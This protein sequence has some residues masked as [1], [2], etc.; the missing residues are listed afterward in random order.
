[1]KRVAL[2]GLRVIGA[3]VTLI[4]V[5]VGATILLLKTNWGG[6]RLRRQ[7]VTRV[8][9]QIQGHLDVQRLAFGGNSLT[10]WEVALRDPDGGTVAHVARVE[11]DFSVT[12]LLHKEINLK[13]IAIESPRLELVTDARGSNLARAT[14]PRKKSPP[15]PPA[16]PKT[17]EEGWVVR[18]DRFDLTGGE[19]VVAAGGE[20]PAQT[21]VHLT[22]LNSF[23]RVRYA[24]GN[25][26]LDLGFRLQGQS[27]VAPVAPLRISADAQVRGDQYR[28]NADGNLLNGT[29]RAHGNVDSAHLDSADAL[30]A[31][32][33]PRQELGGYGWGPLR[34]DA[35]A[36][37]GV[38][39][40][41]DVALSIPGVQLTG[42]SGQNAKDDA[43]TGAKTDGK[44][45]AKTDAKTG[46]K[47][48]TPD[49]D[50]QGRLALD[51]LSLT[52]RAA[53]ALAGG[54]LTLLSGHGQL[55]FGVGGPMAGAPA[56][57]G[58]HVKGAVARV[59]VAETVVD[60]LTIDGKTAH[61]SSQPGQADLNV[62]IASVRT[63]STELK[64]ITLQAK[65]RDALVTA[66]LA[67]VSPRPVSL[68]LAAKL[69]EDRQGLDLQQLTLTYPGGQWANE[70]TARLVFGGDRL[71]IQNF[72]LLSQGQ[73]L[74][75]DAAKTGDDIQA[76]VALKDL[77]LG[78]LPT[79]LVDPKLQLGGVLDA[80]I[81]ADVHLLVQGGR[82]QGFSKIGAKGQVTLE[83]KQV[84]GTLDVDAPFMAIEAGFKLPTDPLAPGAPLDVRLDVKRL[85]VGDALRA[86]AKPAQ[87][88][89]RMTV[90]ARVT[91]SAGDPKVDVV[92]TGKD[93]TV[94]P[95]APAPTAAKSRK[96]TK[97]A[98]GKIA[99]AAEQIDLGHVRVHLTYAERTA[100]ADIDFGSAHGGT[101]NVDASARVDLSYPRVTRGLVVA[102]IPVHGQVAAKDLDV[103]WL[104]QFN[105]RVESLGGQVNAKAKL[106]GTVGDP[107]FVGDVRWKNGKVIATAPE[108][109]AAPAA[110]P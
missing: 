23:I 102:K 108:T 5:V 16:K 98:S 12:R 77:R 70:G 33:I 85:D 96:A 13:A 4:A 75:V 42:Q 20:S 27:V 25:G 110:R 91:G 104:A 95:P 3:L 52:A 66:S 63:G 28:F 11:V 83:D 76:V 6:E 50:F 43:K 72:R 78:L 54:E 73:T 79:F 14:A 60:E 88:D 97:A 24:L 19:V 26:S 46:V 57:W 101:L 86:A 29:L 106:A 87:V 22:G 1:M 21:K 89:G 44:T 92:L 71:S 99:G 36:Q 53:H 68:T 48:A 94:A 107:Q 31:I 55:D 8:N 82:Y 105:P 30:I 35:Q 39:P 109:P 64:N 10:L 74:A 61:L 38:A 2:I 45:D 67:L 40:K 56:T 15:S 34:I 81:K 103:A 84:D 59:R 41:L 100:R 90:R 51:D 17:K 18:L 93:L 69:D 47:T 62:A 49:F 80:D 32:A 9:S 37:P 7:V 58:A 65:A